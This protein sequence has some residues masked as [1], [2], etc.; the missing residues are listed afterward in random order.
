MWETIPKLEYHKIHDI[1]VYTR[2]LLN[3]GYVP[4]A[5]PRNAQ[6]FGKFGVHLYGK[7]GINECY[8]LEVWHHCKCCKKR[9]EHVVVIGKPGGGRSYPTAEGTDVP[10][11]S[12]QY[13][14]Y[15]QAP[16]TAE[17][18]ILA[19]KAD[20]LATTRN[21]NADETKTLYEQ[22]K[23]WEIVNEDDGD[24]EII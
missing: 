1:D 24:W 22:D 19:E 17:A 16:T 11:E 14:P 23:D 20:Q 9:F 18:R 21:L 7:G 10:N 5:V 2:A 3:Q 15:R 12:H 4:E 8:S 6:L 13:I